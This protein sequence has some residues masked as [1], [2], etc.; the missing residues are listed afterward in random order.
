[1]N[2]RRYLAE[3]AFDVLL[4]TY[5]GVNIRPFPNRRPI[6]CDVVVTVVRLPFG[7]RP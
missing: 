6:L 5:V 2:F 4:P 1:M 3:E 7:E